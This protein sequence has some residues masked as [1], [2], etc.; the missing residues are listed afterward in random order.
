M[1]VKPPFNHLRFAEQIVDFEQRNDGTLILRSPHALRAYPNHFCF[2][3]RRW[4]AETPNNV[5]LAERDENDQWQKITYREMLQSVESLGQA[6][7]DRGLSSSRPLMVLSENSIDLAS[8]TLAAL[9]AGVP[10]VPVSPAYS[11]LSQDLMKIRAIADLVTP[12]MIYAANAEPYARAIEAIR[13]EDTTVVISKGT[14]PGS[15]QYK[16]LLQTQPSV[17]LTQAFDRVNP[18]QVA[19][20]LFT[21]GST[22][23]PKG[24][25]TTHRMLCSNQ[26]SIA[27]CWPF[28]E[29]SPPVILDW[30]PWSHAFGANHNFNLVLRNGGS[31]Y[32]DDGK[33]MPGLIEKTVRNLREISPTLYFNAPR[34]FDA[35]LPYLERDSSLRD[36]FFQNLD[37]IFYASAALPQNLWDRLESASIASRGERVHMVSSWGATETTCTAT[38][39]YFTI[40]KAGVIG[41]PAPGVEVMLAPSASKMELRVRGPIVTPG[42]WK[43]PDL[44]ATAYDE[45]GFYKIGDAGKLD[46]QDDPSKGILF[47]GRVAEDFKLLSGTWVHCGQVRLNAISACTPAIQD[48]VITGH[49][50]ETLGLLVFLNQSACR[51]IAEDQ[52][53]TTAELASNPKVHAFI[54]KGLQTYN[55]K[56]NSNSMRIERFTLLPDTPIIDYGE[57]TDK[58]YIN[59]NAVIKRR[60]AVIE[61]MYRDSEDNEF[62]V[63]DSPEEDSELSSAKAV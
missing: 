21:S 11:L 55:Q 4:A 24:V 3:L 33:P 47:D 30:L 18:D 22:G 51:D 25:I 61:S 59:Q 29:D 20:I 15:V 7:L 56:H 10:V 44:T 54:K 49:D 41:L 12:G 48:V 6:L 14:L 38:S 32:I 42:Y 8:L 1:S 31:L 17:A 40:E 9:Y 52:S 13:K 62:V 50:R 34:G 28:M 45:E 46:D 2:H 5:F 57:I 58:G 35:L 36:K 26:Q 43:R 53:L 37:L 19:K 63:N 39:V 16:N 23:E 60:A 27:Q